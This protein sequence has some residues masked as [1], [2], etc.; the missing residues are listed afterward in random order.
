MLGNNKHCG[1]WVIGLAL[2]LCPFRF[3]CLHP[4][5]VGPKAGHCCS[6]LA[7]KALGPFRM[8]H[9]QPTTW[10][11]LD[12]WTYICIPQTASAHPWQIG[13]SVLVR[14]QNH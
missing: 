13:A 5:D 14:N 8:A 11:Q 12:L 1:Y 2:W 4:F 6:Q 3:F 10:L 7:L 9:P